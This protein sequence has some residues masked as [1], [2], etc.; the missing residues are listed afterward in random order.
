MTAT[1]DTA[2]MQHFHALDREQQAT[3]VHR[4]A[5]AGYSEHGIAAATKL[6]VEFVRRILG[7]AEDNA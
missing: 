3:A 7:E 6:S 4:L 5:A 2:R 1:I